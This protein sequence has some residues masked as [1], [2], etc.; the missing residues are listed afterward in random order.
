MPLGDSTTA[1]VLATARSCGDT[2][3]QSGRTFQFIGSR[4]GDPGCNV[5][6]YDRDNEGHGGYI[7]TDILKAAGTGTRPGGADTSYSY[8]SDARDLAAGPMAAR[9]T[10]C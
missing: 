5:T 2:L 3:T 1:S 4:N 7:V 10:S 8:A 9:P 6:G